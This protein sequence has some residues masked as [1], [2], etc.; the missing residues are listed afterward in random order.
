MRLSLM[1]KAK[2][3][4]RKT[5]NHPVTVHFSQ[6]DKHR[7][8]TWIWWYSTKYVSLLTADKSSIACWLKDKFYFRHLTASIPCWFLTSLSA[9]KVIYISKLCKNLVWF[10]ASISCFASSV[11]QRSSV[12]SWTLCVQNGITASCDRFSKER[13]SE[14]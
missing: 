3:V 5:W 12:T 1:F 13:H 2:P 6:E 4:L 8:Q 11:F 10:W 14:T 9:D 7:K